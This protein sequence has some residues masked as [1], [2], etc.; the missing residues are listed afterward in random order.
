MIASK[1]EGDVLLA[2]IRITGALAERLQAIAARDGRSVEGSFRLGWRQTYQ[3]QPTI[4]RQ[5]F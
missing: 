3:R 2:E 1:A 5:H 4:G